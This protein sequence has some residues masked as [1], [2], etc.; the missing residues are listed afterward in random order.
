M[1]LGSRSRPRYY[2]K[3]SYLGLVHGVV[4]D[5]NRHCRRARIVRSSRGHVPL[6]SWFSNPGTRGRIRQVYLEAVA[7]HELEEDEDT[8]LKHVRSALDI[9]DGEVLVRTLR[10]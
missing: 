7:D 1:T 6:G 8:V 3:V 5:G 9:S 2:C 10:L 4:T